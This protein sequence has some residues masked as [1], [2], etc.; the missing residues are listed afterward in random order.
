MGAMWVEDLCDFAAV[1]VGV[2]RLHQL[3]R[4]L[5]PDRRAPAD[6]ARERRILVTPLPGEQ[7]SFGAAM[8]AAFFRNAGWHV[9]SGPVESAQDLASIVHQRR[10]AIVGLSLGSSARLDALAT[11]IRAVRRA[12]CNPAVG[13]MVGGG[14]F[15]E[16]PELVRLVGADATAADAR[17]APVQAMSLMSLLTPGD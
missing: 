11:T 3:L 5:T 1:S 7:H 2:W 6:P 10:F 4:N 12:S 8:V 13:V 17:S 14:L 16:Q 15:N 9:F